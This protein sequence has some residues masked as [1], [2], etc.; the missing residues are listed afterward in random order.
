MFFLLLLS[1]QITLVHVSHIIENKIQIFSFYCYFAVWVLPIYL[2]LL[3][4]FAF[5]S[6]IFAM[7]PITDFYFILLIS[8]SCLFCVLFRCFIFFQRKNLCSLIAVCCCCV[9]LKL[10]WSFRRFWQNRFCCLQKIIY[11]EINFRFINKFHV[12]FTA[13]IVYKYFFPFDLHCTVFFAALQ[14]FIATLSHTKRLLT[15]TLII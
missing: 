14:K 9:R 2:C 3:L 7:S 1:L 10:F 13:P 5:I 6:V 11:P 12:L 8:L 15:L 4:F